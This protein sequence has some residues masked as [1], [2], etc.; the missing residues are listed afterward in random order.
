MIKFRSVCLVVAL[1]LAAGSTVLASQPPASSWSQGGVTNLLHIPDG[2]PLSQDINT[3]VW[4]PNDFWL[5]Q[6]KRIK[7]RAPP[8]T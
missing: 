7:E 6:V 3:L 5:M 4:K 1:A 2:R 8:M